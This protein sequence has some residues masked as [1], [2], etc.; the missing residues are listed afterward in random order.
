MIRDPIF[1]NKKAKRQ[2][3]EYTNSVC[4]REHDNKSSIT[5]HYFKLGKPDASI[6]SGKGERK[7]RKKEKKE[8]VLVEEHTKNNKTA[9][10]KKRKKKRNIATPMP[11]EEK[12]TPG[13]LRTPSSSCVDDDSEKIQIETDSPNNNITPPPPQV[14]VII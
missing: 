13:P 1:Y 11:G 14:E 8:N 12:E 3:A 7:E 9:G 4:R 6:S 10:K 5:H 2:S